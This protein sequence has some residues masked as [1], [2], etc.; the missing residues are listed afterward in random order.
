MGV[1]ETVKAADIQIRDPFIVPSSDE[2]LYYLYGTTDSDPFGAKAAG[3]TAYTSRD[4]QEWSEPFDVFRPGSGF[5][6]DKNFWAP[7]VHRHRDRWFMFATF[8]AD[9][10]CRGTQV[11]VSDSLRGP[12]RPHS[13]GPVTPRDWE[14]LDGTLFVDADGNPWIVFCHEWVQVKDGE[15]C[16]RRLSA[17]L[18]RPIGEPILLF[19]ASEA[20]WVISS[21]EKDTWVTDGPFVYRSANGNLLMLWSSFTK[22]GYAQGLA[23][24]ESGQITGP[25]AH[26][27]PLY[28]K[29]GGHGMLF[30]TFD[31]KLMLTLHTPNETP[32]ERP[33]FLPVREANGRI[34]VG[35]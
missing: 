10:V 12:F 17:D 15:I 23:R 20:P 5:W 11:L 3:F 2:R 6:A 28:T 21:P 19:R 8:K 1:D 4:L 34:P 25:W 13:D 18:T 29:D 16:A 22:D 31:G 33:I 24:S 7:E 30:R 9:G 35:E 14:C 26:D 32:N 27:E